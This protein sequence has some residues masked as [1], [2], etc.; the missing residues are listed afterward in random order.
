MAGIEIALQGELALGQLA[1]APQDTDEVVI[2]QGFSRMIGRTIGLGDDQQV[3][4]APLQI[5]MRASDML[6]EPEPH[7]AALLGRQ[8]QYMGDQDGHRIVGDEE[9]EFAIRLGGV[10][11]RLGGDRGVDA[12]QN[13]AYGFVERFGA[14][15]ELHAVADLDQQVVLKVVAQACQSVAHGRLAQ[16]HPLAGARDIAL[17]Q[18]GIERHEEV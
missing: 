4:V 5:E 10:E 13:V 1:V 16:V 11:L 14:G 8:R 7:P 6:L 9:G 17:G 12:H 2:E 3:G 15:S 18:Q